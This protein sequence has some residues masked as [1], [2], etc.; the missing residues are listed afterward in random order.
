MVTVG[1]V[2]SAGAGDSE[3]G[4]G[5]GLLLEGES[6]GVGEPPV[7]GVA[8]G[9]VRGG[10]MTGPPVV[11]GAPGPPVVG[12]A[13]GVVGTGSD[14]DNVG[15]GDGVGL[16]FGDGLGNRVGVSLGDGV[17]AGGATGTPSP[18]LST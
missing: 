17:P 15:E 6:L 8:G 4:G 14:G 1:G 13:P 7:D 3:V 5:D 9:V 12:G 10:G 2:L 16:G 18:Q 11:G